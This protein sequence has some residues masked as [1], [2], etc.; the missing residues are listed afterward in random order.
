[1]VWLPGL[2]QC[3]STT[4]VNT[5]PNR[6]HRGL[7]QACPVVQYRGSVRSER[8][9]RAMVQAKRAVAN[10]E[11]VADD[12]DRFRDEFVPC[13]SMIQRVASILDDESRG[14]RTPAFG[15]AD[16]EDAMARL[17]RR[18]RSVVLRPNHRRQVI[19]RPHVDIAKVLLAGLAVQEGPCP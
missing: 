8:A 7:R 16:Q 11:V 12:S 6:S 10:L 9:R 13:I 17:W 15:A 18:R 2:L 1:M 5:D 3:T 4:T 19:N 14:H